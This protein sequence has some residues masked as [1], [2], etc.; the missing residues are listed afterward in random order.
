MSMIGEFGI[1][2]N[3][4]RKKKNPGKEGNIYNKNEKKKVYIIDQCLK[5]RLIP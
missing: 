4:F 1:E 2:E 5:I 3:Y